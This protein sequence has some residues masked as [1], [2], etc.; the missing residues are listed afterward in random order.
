RG[1]GNGCEGRTAIRNTPLMMRLV[2]SIPSRIA[3]L[4]PVSGSVSRVRYEF[5]IGPWICPAND[6]PNRSARPKSAR[7]RPVSSYSDVAEVALVVEVPLIDALDRLQPAPVV[8]DAREL[9]HPRPHAVGRPFGDPQTDFRLALH[10]VLP[11]VRLFES[12]AEDATDR[13]APHDGPQFF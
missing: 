3:C 5:C 12:D 8:E 10:R 7:C 6:T 9:R 11:P 13:P 1:E 2:S 4:R